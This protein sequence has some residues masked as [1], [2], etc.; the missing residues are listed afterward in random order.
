MAGSALDTFAAATRGWFTGA[1]SAPTAAQEGAWR[2][3][4]RG[5]DVLVVAPTGSGK[6]L[7]AFL[8]ALDGLTSAPPP[9]DAKKRCRVLYV[10]PLKALAVDVERNL[11]SPLT[12]IRQEAVRLGLPE[13][14]V[15]VGIRSGDTPA[16]ERRALATRPPDILITTP[17]SL[18]LMLTSAGRESLSGVETV[19]VDEVHAVAGT[20]RGAHLALSLERLDGLLP[21]PARR[22]GLSATVR[23]VDEVARYLSPGRRA[24][25][26]QPP[27]GKEF[28]LSVVVPVEDMGELGG[29]PA[30]EP[31]G[32]GEKPSIWPQVEERIADLVQAHRSTIVFANSRRLAERLCNRLNEIAYERTMGK[33]LPDG[34]PPAEIMAQSGAAQGA[35]PLLARAHH[36]SVSKEQRALVEEDLKA[37]R[38]P[39]VVATSSLE[40]GIDMGAVDLVVQVES[41][42]SVASGLQRVGRAGH[43]VGAVST[44]VVFPKYRGDLVQA[45][46][47]TERMRTGAIE[48]LRVPANPLDVL[49]QQLVAMVALDTWQFD[50]LLAVVRRAAPFA[51][52]PESAF[53]AVLDML[54]GRYPS[55]AFAELRPRVVWDRVAGTVTGRPG[56]QRLAVTSGG[57]IPDR[58]LFG[59]FL[60]GADPQKG[61]GRV[62]ELDEEMVYESR[63]GDVF[64]L[65]TTSWRIEDITR[66]RVLV[67]PA[68]GAPGRL[69]FWKGDQLGRPLELGR[70]V[71][72]FLREIGSLPEEDARLRLMTAGLD[73]WAAGNVLS[74][75]D[76]QR[77]ACGHVP[78]DRTIVVERFR[79]ELGD[80]RVV[81]HSP[82]GAQVHAP[83]A[84]ALGARLSERYGMDAQVMHADDGIVLRLPD[85]DLMGLDLLDQDQVHPDTS[86][87]GDQAPVGAGD[88]LFG[89]GEIGQIVTDQVGGSALFASR[90]RECAARALLLPRR[91]PGKRTP[92]W[93][94]RQRAAQ[95]LQVA[96]E[97][98]SFPIVLEAVR[99][100]LQDVFDVP[101]LEELMGDIESRKVRLV[102]VTTPEPSPFARSLLFGYVAQFLYEGDSP[103][104][105]RRAAALSLDS[106]LLAEL[107]GRAEL[108]ELLDADVLDELERELQWLTDDRRVKDVEG[109]ADLLRVLGPL[110]TGELT[111]RGAD[112]GWPG[113]LAGTRR[114]IRVRIAGA[115][116]WA[117]VED[118]G[119]L[120]DALGTALPVGVPEAF[121]EPV[122]DPLGDLLARFARTH[123]PFTSSQA[124]ARFGLGA[125]V[126]DGALQRLAAAGRVVQGEFHPSGIGQEWCDAT[127][128]RRLR[129]RSLAVLRQE[130]EPVPP[131]AL[132]TFLPQWQH[133]GGTGLR[134]IDGLARTV[135]QL[136]G[137]PVPASALEK[138]ILP[139]RVA[140]YTPGMLD[141]LTT[142]GEV[143][144]AGAGA[145]PGKDGWVSL[146]HADA[147]PLLLPQPHPLEL[148]ALHESVLR[149]LAGGYGLFFR[150]IADQVRATTH[151]E[152][153]DP[154]LA[155]ALWELAWSGR[156]T[157][158]TLAPLRS[159]LGSGR[160]AGSTAHRAR[161]TV[162]RGRYGSLTSAART[163]SR[164]GP[165]TVSGR[166]SLLPA[167]EP[168]PTHRAHALARTLLDRHGVVTRGAVAAEGVE[169]GFSATYRI[170]SVFEDSGQARRGYVVEGLGA[171]QF[172]MDGAV[173]RLRAAAGA[174][175]RADGNTA[176][177][178]TV[179][180][181]A[182]PANVYGAAL[183]WPEPPVGATHKPGRKAG[184]LVVL[185]DGELTL[186]LERGGKTLL[187]WPSEPDDP[188]LRA[189][190]GALAEAGGAGMLG[191]ITVERINGAPALTSPLSRPLE[192]SGFH[193]TPRGLRIRA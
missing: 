101:G 82:F 174:R 185:V 172:A 139:S 151:P 35:P 130:L 136:Q 105:E 50:D 97:F 64:T 147:A 71:G 120:R 51:S 80:W 34:A 47:V 170:L 177:R 88:T 128:L 55:D 192:E 70:A 102:E 187:F 146:Y 25:I 165:P 140:G 61:G 190:A 75:L 59:V 15:R 117:V 126:T 65:G 8:A 5:S 142:S 106:R 127:V 163:A 10:S 58:G 116:H 42:P 30:S 114:A 103:L 115:E 14:E 41:P 121:T 154:Q 98:G 12:G 49:A 76:E 2:A 108:R 28:D 92:L 90:F 158:D 173:D 31:D 37:G 118:A 38:L 79:D 188:A 183:P 153:T 95:L 46:V 44:G 36:G 74:Y 155:D 21:R 152:V 63:V 26:V 3:I 68:P 161:R 141:E 99:E 89:K 60:A 191:T 24:E 179:L 53:T 119:R 48:S 32:P 54:A 100:C 69:P 57:T 138:L 94:Q 180:A 20:K 13:P 156:L 144:W 169:G 166:W 6:T 145:L 189:A 56:A 176:P 157:N 125:A 167:H 9:A 16:A 11:R 160:T 159:L 18:F 124:A 164:N 186:Y 182:D 133:L 129:R 110:T 91:N 168:D 17:E 175:E 122:K 135:E 22:I 112:P 1:F 4:G 77:R 96:S 62:G 52:L 81:V 27:S 23:P 171:A 123:G 137:A 131:A 84:L 113:E 78:D 67:S 132:A 93:Q 107:L 150:H 72:A 33:P 87:D 73:G 83:W 111:E 143:V 7:A 29:S 181:A 19:I 40:L 178:A 193:A 134:G 39:A 45:A 109:V 86:Y 104:A 43:Q 148:T 162:P 149:T 184:S 66:D 85:A